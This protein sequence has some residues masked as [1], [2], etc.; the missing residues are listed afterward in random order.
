MGKLDLLIEKE[1]LSAP[2]AQS[3]SSQ[4]VLPN[5]SFKALMTR[6]KR[7]SITLTKQLNIKPVKRLAREVE[8]ETC[9]LRLSNGP[10]EAVS[11]CKIRMNSAWL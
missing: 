10:R 8:L 3:M 4:I 6:S 1:N 5:S 2:S 9:G 7:F 11:H